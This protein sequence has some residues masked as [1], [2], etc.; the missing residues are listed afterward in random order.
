MRAK[1]AVLWILIAGMLWG[2]TGTAQTFAPEQASPL[3]LGAMRL[4]IGGLTLF[5]IVW[6]RGS[7]SLP[8]RAFVPVCFAAAAMASYQ[9]LFFS[10]VK[11]TGVAVGTVV[12]IGSA[13][14]LSGILEWLLRRKSPEKKWY[15]ATCLAILGCV[16]LLMNE[17]EVNISLA[18]VLMALGAGLSFSVYTI[19]SKQLVDRQAPESVVALIFTLSALLLIPLF[20]FYDLSWLYEPRGIGVVLHLGLVTTALAY[21]LFTRGLIYV[22]SS[23]AV[24]LALAEP[25][26][27]ALLGVLVVREQLTFQAWIGVSLLLM[28]LGMISFSRSSDKVEAQVSK[29]LQGN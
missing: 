13:P 7:F 20:F 25:L 5:L 4:F 29:E 6:F 16:F 27:A 3:I 18:G 28:G 17:S 14:I 23:K 15:G 19:M 12:A 2:T 1:A 9:P 24:T 11:Q 26:T 22:S 21:L 8:S 10:A